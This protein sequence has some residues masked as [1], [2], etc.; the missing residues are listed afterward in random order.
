MQENEQPME[1][2]VAPILETAVISEAAITTAKKRGRLPKWKFMIEKMNIGDYFLV[3]NRGEA[4]SCR[5]SGYTHFRFRFKTKRQ[6][7]GQI[8]MERSA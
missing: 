6:Q 8:R 1:A 5:S 2:I 3:Q 7:G 4:N